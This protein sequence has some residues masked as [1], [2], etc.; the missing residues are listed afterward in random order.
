ME[1]ALLKVDISVGKIGGDGGRVTPACEIYCEKLVNYLASLNG[2]VV[3]LTPLGQQLLVSLNTPGTD[4]RALLRAALADGLKYEEAG[5]RDPY[6]VGLGD[7]NGVL[8]MVIKQDF[9]DAFQ[10]TLDYAI[11]DCQDKSDNDGEYAD[12]DFLVTIGA[13]RLKIPFNINLVDGILV[14]EAVA[15]SS[16]VIN[17]C[18]CLE[19]VPLWPYEDAR[20][21]LAPDDIANEGTYRLQPTSHLEGSFVRNVDYK[22]V[23]YFYFRDPRFLQG[24]MSMDVIL[25]SDQPSWKNL[26]VYLN[27][28]WVPSIAE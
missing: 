3:E 17:K 16:D 1:E 24:I 20:S 11:Y 9:L 6:T 26:E 5:E 12:M 23:N 4:V 2:Y 15:W 27:G 21:T 10:S 8:S 22:G 28:Q 7:L 14:S 18:L 13:R 25:E 19:R